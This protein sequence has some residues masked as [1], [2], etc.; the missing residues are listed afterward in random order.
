MRIGAKDKSPNGLVDDEKLVKFHK[1]EWDQLKP[2]VLSN[3]RQTTD[4]VL[5]DIELPDDWYGCI[6]HCLS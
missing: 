4:S 6:M 1:I 3:Y 5:S 2:D